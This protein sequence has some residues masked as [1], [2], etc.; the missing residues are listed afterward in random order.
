[1]RSSSIIIF[2]ILS[3]FVLIF[4]CI[5]LNIVTFY[6]ELEVSASESLVLKPTLVLR[7]RS[8]TFIDEL[9]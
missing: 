4:S 8:L 6:N 1:M 3:A 7:D 9:K 5:S 2:G